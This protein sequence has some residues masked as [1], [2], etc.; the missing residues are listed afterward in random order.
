MKWLSR[1]IL[2]ARGWRFVGAVPDESKYVAVG[3]PHTSNWDFFVYLA[4]MDHF[5]I[6][7]RFLAKEGLFRGPLGWLM[8]RWGGIS[9]GTATELVAAA[10]AS[11]ESHDEMVL[12]IA[13]EGTRSKTKAWKSGFW[14]IADAADVPVVM[15]FV[16]GETK[17]AGLGPAARIDGDPERWIGLAADFYEDKNG[18]EPRNRS[19]VVL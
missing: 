9:I 11:F 14:R 1:K 5:E 10:V 8:R 18:L 16:D 19:P 13:P 3:F 2:I 17:R 15:G 4:V 12:V 7:A 6:R